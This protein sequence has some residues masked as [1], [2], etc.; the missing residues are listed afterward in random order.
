MNNC[1]MFIDFYVQHG[2]IE[3]L[4]TV[5]SIYKPLSECSF[6]LSVSWIIGLRVKG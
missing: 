2:S 1:E 5:T 6:T 3:S 4:E